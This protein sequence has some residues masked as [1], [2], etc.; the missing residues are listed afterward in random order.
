MNINAAEMDFQELNKNIR[1]QMAHASETPACLTVT[2]GLGQRFMGCGL[3]DGT[4]IIDGVPGNAMGAYLNG[5]K[6]IVKGNAQDAA[7][8]TMNDG[9]IY[10][11]GSSGDATGY[12]MRGGKI[13]VKGNAG[14]RA[15]IHIKAYEDKFPVIVIGGFAGSFLGEY[16]AGG[17]ILVLGLNRDEQ[18]PI[19]GYFCGTGMH[20]GKMVLRCSQPPAD[21][22]PQVSVEQASAEDIAQIRPYIEE[23]CKAFA[24]CAADVLEHTFYVLTPDTSNPYKRLYCPNS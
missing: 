11:H 16:Q 19:V 14:Y 18:T 7:G 6:I 4:L 12:A 20:G 9:V 15:G 8:D 17:L 3:S 13:F 10:I 2:N 24:C 23:Y 21:L 5:A 22:P 1:E